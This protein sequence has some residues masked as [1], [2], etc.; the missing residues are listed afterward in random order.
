M[1]PH[2]TTF[3]HWAI[4]AFERHSQRIFKYEPKVL[5]DNDPED[6]HQLRVG[7]RRLRS[8]IAGF[9]MAVK[10]PDSIT[11]KKIGSMA[12]VLGVQRDNDVLQEILAEKYYPHLPPAEQKL[13]NDVLKQLKKDRKQAFKETHKLLTQGKFIT[14]KHQWQT[15]LENPKITSIG[16]LPIAALL[17]DLLLPQLSQFFLHP[18]WLIGTEIDPE[19]YQG[20]SRRC[21]NLTPRVVQTQLN[22][23]EKTLH[24]L[25]KVAKRT[26]YQLELFSECYGEDYQQL[27]SQVKH[28]QEILGNLQ[29]SFV[30]RQLI[31]NCLDVDLARLT[32]QLEAIFQGDRRQCWAQWQSL[33]TQFIDSQY[34]HHCRQLIEQADFEGQGLRI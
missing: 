6:L 27:L 32:P 14:F 9:G 13:L 33:Q 28:V 34:R 26:R 1:N 12:R 21:L 30:L 18:G 4:L 31:E 7:M 10:L 29:D 25:R 24:D 2:G 3:G 16:D 19:N 5:K 23:Q 17:P 22:N 20:L 15:W 11:E 8:A